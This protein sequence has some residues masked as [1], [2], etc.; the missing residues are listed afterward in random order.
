MEKKQTIK[1]TTLIIKNNY[2]D[3]GLNLPDLELSIKAH[4]AQL[5]ITS[6]S[7]SSI[8]KSWSI[9]RGRVECINGNFDV[10]KIPANNA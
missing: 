6:K 9:G 7:Y 1:Y 2:E 4:Y 3:G 5:L 10:R 8:G